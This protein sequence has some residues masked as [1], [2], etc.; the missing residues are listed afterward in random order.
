[1]R[2]NLSDFKV[3]DVKTSQRREVI[4]YGVK[5]V[6]GPLEWAETKGAGIK[7]GVIDT[8]VALNHPDLKTRVKD[9]VNFTSS[10]RKNVLDDNGHGTHV[11]GIVAAERN[12]LGVVGVAPEADL[13]IAKAFD[14]EGYAEFDAI[15]KSIQWMMERDVDVINMSFSAQ[16]AD[17]GYQQIISQA[18]NQG[19]TLVCAAGN[20][21]DGESA[22]ANTIGYPAKFDQ[23]IAVTAVDMNKRRADFSSVGTEAEIAA[24]GKDVYSCYL[25]SKYATLSGTSMATPII[26]G[27]VA[28]LQAKGVA[29][30]KRRL[31]PE[32]IR[33]LLHVYAED[34]GTVGRDRKYGFG[35]FSF[36]RINKSDYVSRSTPVN[37]SIAHR[38]A[39]VRRNIGMEMMIA[40]ALLIL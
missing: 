4:D 8:G 29:R 5:M 37:M 10:E 2:S 33:L 27:A 34:L 24:A 38:N 26:T 19:I 31:T 18:Y 30:Y 21:G 13:Y 39:A 28:L 22:D 12:N 32:E 1:M 35:L 15:A 3:L 17:Q 40:A 20:R 25:D 23:T 6:G 36:G 7:V 16:T 9:Y 11:A 14:K